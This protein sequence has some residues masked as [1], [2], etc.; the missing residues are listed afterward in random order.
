M[1]GLWLIGAAV[2]FWISWLL[3]PGVGVTD[4]QQIFELV[5]SRRALVI[6]SVVVQLASAALYVP[7]MVG[8]IADGVLGRLAAIRWSAGLLLAGAMGS[9]ADAVLHLL[10]YAMTAPGL[11]PELFIPVMAYLQGPGLILLGP[12]IAS[13][14]VGG[15]ALSIGLARQGIVPV[16]N[17]SLHGLSL[18]VAVFGGTAAAAGFVPAR[19]VGLTALALVSAAQA[20]AGLGLW[21]R[22]KGDSHL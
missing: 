17:P 5:S 11:V 21:K 18:M 4:P 7:A 15:A 14:F 3:M 16:S 2:L 9:A 13:F 8:L 22:G 6:S 19:L 10:A 1:S 12:F 20:Q